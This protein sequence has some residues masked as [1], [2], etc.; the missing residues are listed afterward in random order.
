[1]SRPEALKRVLDEIEAAGVEARSDQEAVDDLDH[2]A[3]LSGIDPSKLHAATLGDDLIMIRPEHADCIIPSLDSFDARRHARPTS[4]DHT[5][6][7]ASGDRQALK[8]A[9]KEALSETLH[10]EREFL[11]E[12]LAEVLE[13]LALGEAIRE[14]LE[15]PPATREDVL[16]AI[17]GRV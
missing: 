3:R 11:H 15:T 6:A 2:A 12:V 9:L 1:M 4:E 5:M 14:G 13:D 8:Q 16:D 17:D 10:E 7:E